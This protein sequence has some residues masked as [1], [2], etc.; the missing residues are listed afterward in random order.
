M[1]VK[2]EVLEFDGK[3]Q[4]D[5][6]ID[7]LS[8]VERIFDLID[9]PD[10]VKVKLVAI[11]LCKYA[12]LWWDHVKKKRVQ[13]GKSKIETWEKMKKLLREKFLPSNYRQ[14]AFLEYHNLSQRN[15]TFEDLIGEFDKLRMRCAV[16]EE[17]EQLVARFLGALQPEI[18]DVVQLQ[19]YWS[20]NDVC[21]LALKVEKQL[22]TRSK[23]VKLGPIKA[24]NTCGATPAPATNRLSPIK[25]ENIGGSPNLA[26]A[27]T[28]VN[29]CF[30]CHGLGHFARECPN[31]HLVTFSEDTEPIYDTTGEEEPSY[32]DEVVYP[33]K[34]E[35]LIVQ[36]AL[37]IAPA[38]SIGDT[39]WLRNNIFRTKCTSKG[40]ICTIIIDG[41]SCENMVA[42][43]MV[44]KLG[45]KVEPHPD[46]YQ[47]TWFKK[48]NVV[49]VT[50]RCLVQFSI[51][52]RYS[53]EVWYEV[54]PMDAC[55]VLL[56]R[57]WQYDR[58][59]KHDGFKNTYSFRKDGIN[60]TL[61]PLD[62]RETNS[63]AVVLTES[64]FID[65]TRITT[66]HFIHALVIVEQNVTAEEVPPVVC[67]LLKEFQDV[68]PED[69]PAGLPLMRE[70]QHCI[71]LVPGSVI[72]NKPA[73]RMNPKEFQELHRQVTE[74]LDKGLIRESMSPCALPALLVPKPGGAYPM[75]V[76]SRAVNKITIKYHFPIP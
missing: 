72:P 20:Y 17:E 47:L 1:G 14:E 23:N 61:A 2:V 10:K 6:F 4:P 46:R 67:P 7:W 11:K 9:I 39:L 58:R 66:P 22:K 64:A 3:A 21:Q 44:E 33:D 74:L 28:I 26:A 43:S 13:E 34:G 62:T 56:G 19:P 50:Q 73:Y 32:Y 69:I 48:G 24:E 59:T 15:S 5:E 54:I 51:G 57:P 76:D 18:A 70:I 65:F 8:T 12:S 29:R 68:F 49:K 25:A 40:K 42:T 45:L 30:K 31:K 38:S 27:S 37:S 16:E 52:N 75:C 63:E 71:D 60:I 53:D 36:R 41:G 35:S 55:H